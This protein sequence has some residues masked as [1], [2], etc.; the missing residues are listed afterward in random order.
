MDRKKKAI[1]EFEY[2]RD[3]AELR[4]LSK[5]SLEQPLSESQYKR[6][7]ELGRKMKL[8]S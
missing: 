8:V 6:M 5:L 2:M 4:A 7:K 3:M 1:A